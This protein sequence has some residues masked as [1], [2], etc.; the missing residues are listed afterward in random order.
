[1]GG[2]EWSRCGWKEAKLFLRNL[3]E[4]W[5]IGWRTANPSL[6]FSLGPSRTLRSSPAATYVLLT[7]DNSSADLLFCW[8]E[9]TGQTRIGFFFYL[10]NKTRQK[11]KAQSF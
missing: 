3:W 5:E 7:K 10:K 6:P 9:I 1:M 11:T 4:T 2:R 8:K